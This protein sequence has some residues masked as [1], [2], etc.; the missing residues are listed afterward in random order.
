MRN[1]LLSVTA[2]SMM[3]FQAD[4]QPAEDVWQRFGSFPAPSWQT[5]DDPE[6]QSR[7]DVIKTEFEGNRQTIYELIPK[8]QTD[9]NW[10]KRHW[11]FVAENVRKSVL[12]V[13][14]SYLARE[15]EDCATEPK[16]ADWDKEVNE[17]LFVVFCGERKTDGQGYLAVVWMAKD[18]RTLFRVS[19]E[20]RGPTYS[21]GDSSTY[22]WN[23]QDLTNLIASMGSAE[24]N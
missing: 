9:K 21:F 22:F 5:V 13:R 4:A 7:K 18:R 1:T 20:W 19:E 14:N 10:R 11:V 24:L 2:L 3:A 16:W 6:A 8:G 15:G 23:R 12:K 17:T